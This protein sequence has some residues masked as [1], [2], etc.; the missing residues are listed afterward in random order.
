MI[1]RW[2]LLFFWIEVQND[3]PCF[4]S[5]FIVLLYE[6]KQFV[7]HAIKGEVSV[8]VSAKTDHF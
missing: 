6:T 7:A 2:M 4:F 1:I 5:M 8:F 3:I